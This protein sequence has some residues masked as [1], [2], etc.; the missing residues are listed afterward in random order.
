MLKFADIMQKNNNDSNNNKQTNKNH[1]LQLL[2]DHNGDA[3][4]NG[5]PQKSRHTHLSWCSMRWMKQERK[6]I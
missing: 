3:Y 4:T 6:I 5:L 2:G 1:M